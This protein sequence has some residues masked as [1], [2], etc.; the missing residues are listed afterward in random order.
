MVQPIFKRKSEGEDYTEKLGKELDHFPIRNQFITRW[1]LLAIG[2]FAILNASVLLLTLIIKTWRGVQ[3]HGRGFLLWAFSMPVAPYVLLFVTGV[4]LVYLAKIFWWDG[5]TV[6]EIGL[7]KKTREHDQIWRYQDCQR[8][9]NYIT[10]IK[11]G[12]SIIAYRVKLILE[13]ESNRN[14]V[15]RNQY[16]RME[17]LI[18]IIRLGVLPGLLQRARQ[19]IL[20]DETLTFHHEIKADRNGLNIKGELIPYNQITPEIKNEVLKLYQKDDQ[21][22]LIIKSHLEQISNLD[23]LLDLIENPPKES[24]QSSPK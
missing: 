5:I 10:Q 12:G 24:D 21:N 1:L 11:L 8:F 16:D 19:R 20:R 14:L 22:E 9:D 15:I 6:F 7:L 17:E 18:E 3:I 23:L 2:I 13:D 4:L